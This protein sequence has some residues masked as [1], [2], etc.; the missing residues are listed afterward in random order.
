MRIAVWVLAGA[1]AIVGTGALAYAGARGACCAPAVAHAGASPQGVAG[2]KTVTLAIEGMTC[3]A[4]AVGVKKALRSIDGVSEVKMA[5]KGAV[6]QYD[7]AK[8]SP[9][10][11]VEAVSKLGYKASVAG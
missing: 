6:V 5:D 7:P 1:T 11:M 4:C 8:A 2:T 3:G 10:Q 9:A